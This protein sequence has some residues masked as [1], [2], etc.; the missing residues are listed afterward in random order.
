MS[1]IATS[2]TS[3]A[4]INDL[5]IILPLAIFLFCIVFMAGGTLTTLVH[6]IKRGIDDQG[7]LIKNLL[8]ILVGFALVMAF[9]AMLSI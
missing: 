7:E 6:E 4:G 5:N 3:G 2:F 8:T 1:D 9:F